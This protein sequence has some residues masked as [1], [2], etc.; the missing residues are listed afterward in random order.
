M[1]EI[2]FALIKSDNLKKYG[3]FHIKQT[4]TVID[5]PGT[6]DSSTQQAVR[7]KVAPVFNRLRDELNDHIEDMRGK[8]EK[9]LQEGKSQV[10]LKKLLAK[11]IADRVDK[12]DTMLQKAVPLVL[13]KDAELS[14]LIE[15][16]LLKLKVKTA[17]TVGSLAWDAVEVGGGIAGAITTGGVSLLATV[18]G[19]IAIVK[20]INETIEAIEDLTS[21]E[22]ELRKQLKAKLKE[23]AKLKPPAKV[24]SSLVDEIERLMRTYPLRVAEVQKSVKP[25]ATQLDELLAKTEKAEFPDA[26]QQKAVEGSVQKLINKVIH[27]NVYCESGRKLA[28]S[29][30]DGAAEAKSRRATDWNR[31]WGVLN[32]L[33]DEFC[34]LEGKMEIE[35]I[36]DLF[37]DEAKETLEEWMELEDEFDT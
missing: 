26:K 22:A 5:L 32:D 15:S 36:M 16:S 18:R 10:Q 24:P 27:I 28:T 34:D 12:L 21:E 2:A 4:E 13:Q 19:C 11:D 25:L 23:L 30:K 3:A 7:D 29:A 31:V 6:I 14:R 35:S 17:W 37:K 1:A 33:Y 9:A 20:A 8:I